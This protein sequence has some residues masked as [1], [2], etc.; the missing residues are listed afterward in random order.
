M[1]TVQIYRGDTP[2]L[3]FTVTDEDGKIIDLTDYHVYFAVKL[4]GSVVINR[5]ASVYDPNRGLVRITLSTTETD[6]V[7]TGLGELEGRTEDGS[8]NTFGQFKVKFLE[9]VRK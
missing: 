7:G 4:K 1:E 5:E 2:L 8:V 3:E 6:Y 9:D